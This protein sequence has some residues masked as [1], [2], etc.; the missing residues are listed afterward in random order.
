MLRSE[1]ASLGMRRSLPS[2]L[3]GL[4]SGVGLLLSSMLSHFPLGLP[5]LLSLLLPLS[6]DATSAHNVWLLLSDQATFSEPFS[7][8]K[9]GAWL[10]LGR[11]EG[12]W[13]LSQPREVASEGTCIP[14]PS[15]PSTPLPS[16]PSHRWC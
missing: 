9:M 2:V 15:L 12:E 14:L 6:S 8:Q 10:S 13:L 7:L 3:Q 16:L 11:E 5:P 4:S 1:T